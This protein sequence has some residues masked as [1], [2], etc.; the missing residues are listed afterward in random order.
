MG[1][2]CPCPLSY[3]VA[4]DHFEELGRPPRL[5]H[6]GFGLITVGGIAKARYHALYLLAQLGDV[7]LPVVAEGDGADGLVQSWASCREDGSLAVL[8]WNHT[9]D[10]SKYAGG[11]G[12]D[13]RVR[14]ALDGLGEF[15]D[16]DPIAVRVTRL[17]REH[18][19][20]SV[21]AEQ[22][23]IGDWPTDEQWDQLREADVLTSFDVPLELVDGRYVVELELPQPGAVLIEL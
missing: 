10:Q 3:W 8:V 2:C 19:D 4:S 13:R 22:L 9:L 15:A 16:S 20:L 23:G 14:L 5:L 1:I 18:G 17:D 11:A 6:G 21:L 12:L 7:E